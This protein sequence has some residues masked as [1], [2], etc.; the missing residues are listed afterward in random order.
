MEDDEYSSYYDVPQP[1]VNDSSISSTTT[2]E[3][4]RNGRRYTGP[5]RNLES[6]EDRLKHHRTMQ[7]ALRGHL[8]R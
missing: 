6:K 3:T 8:R 4:G 5:I 7:N 1:H 2:D